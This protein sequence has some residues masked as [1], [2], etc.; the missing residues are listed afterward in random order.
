MRRLSIRQMVEQRQVRLA[1]EPI[2]VCGN[3]VQLNSDLLLDSTGETTRMSV[4]FLPN[5][6]SLSRAPRQRIISLSCAF[7]IF[8][9]YGSFLSQILETS[10]APDGLLL[11][12]I[13]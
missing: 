6:F 7:C 2:I 10:S 3:M 13:A 12:C 8:S 4:L 11:R 1:K 9:I 5:T